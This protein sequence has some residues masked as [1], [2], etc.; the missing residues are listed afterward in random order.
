MT[1][2]CRP[3][4]R[5]PCHASE[6][7]GSLSS[8]TR[9]LFPPAANPWQASQGWPY[10]AAGELRVRCFHQHSHTTAA[11]TSRTVESRKTDRILP[12]TIGGKAMAMGRSGVGIA[13]VVDPSNIDAVEEELM[14]L[15]AQHVPIGGDEVAAVDHLESKTIKPTKGRAEEVSSLCVCACVWSITPRNND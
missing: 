9:T 5:L 13:T 6:L 14:P 8:H 15:E 2:L 3:L 10:G 11:T 4:T 12:A 7:C 1:P